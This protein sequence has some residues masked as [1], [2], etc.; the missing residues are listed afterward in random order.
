MKK[1]IVVSLA[2][3]LTSSIFAQNGWNE[4]WSLQQVPFQPENSFSEYAK[5]IAGFDTDKDGWG[6]FIT[7][8]TDLDSNYI[9]MYEATG[10]N[11]YEMV[12]YW[13]FPTAGE[14]WFAVAV[15]NLDKNDKEEIVVG[16][17]S[18]I[19]AN[20]VNPSRIFT[21]EWNGTI[22][23]NKYGR[24]KG[25][26]IFQPSFKTNF[27]LPDNAA[28]NPYSMI[29]EDIDN[30]N[31]NELIIGIRSGDRGR[32]VLIASAKGGDLV[33]FGTLEVEYNFQNTENGS[34]FCTITG[35]LDND[36][37]TDIFE[38]VWNLFTLR[39]FEVTG[40]NTYEH[41]NDLEQIYTDKDIDYGSVDG[42]RILD[43]NG[44]GKNELVIAGADD[45]GVER[46]LFLIQNITD[47]STI[48][49][50]DVIEFYYLPQNKRPNG[51]LIQAGLRNMVAGDPDKDGK[52][53]LIINGAESGQIFD[54]EY[55]GE[56]DLADS[57]SWNLNIIYDSFKIFADEV[58]S[59]SASLLTPRH[60]YGDLAN[61]MDG[62]GL[63][64]YVFV[65]YSTDKSIW[66]NDV[67][68]SILESESTTDVKRVNRFIPKDISLNQNYPNPFNPTTNIS[69]GISLK[70]NVKLIVYDL[71]GK[72]IETILDEEKN[73]GNYSINFDG[74]N[75][76]N[77]VYY[78]SLITNG[79]LLTK[80][81]LLMK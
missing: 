17:A 80:K 31:V 22:G 78:Y 13:K 34:N 51:S 29:I 71:L 9:F 19:D 25:D 44:D 37:N 81:M 14:G 53:N 11:T 68:I 24:D 4:V 56:G 16:W 49:A 32:E 60:Y 66:A 61:D 43:I 76:S 1:I 50:D 46:H 2:I 8:Y 54:L 42:M 64:E 45:S 18:K 74:S 23:E 52:I 57:T 20:N 77:G 79:K 3:L 36:G 58:D 73:A 33:G 6:E 65:N 40:E 59:D 70:G 26:G 63:S 35:D 48:T 55:K 10:D 75:L 39:I 28:W 38:M 69:F 72:E 5:V 62:D 67:Y 12:W 7:G 21:F 15:G 41:V 27:G 47:I 30:D